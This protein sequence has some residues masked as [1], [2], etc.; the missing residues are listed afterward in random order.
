MECTDIGP[1]L[2]CQT[3]VTRTANTSGLEQLVSNLRTDQTPQLHRAAAEAMT[4]NGTSFFRDPILFDI[5]RK[6]ILPQLFKANHADRKLRIWSAATS[7]GQE[8][9]SVAML[10]A[11]Y[12]PELENWDIKIL[13]TDISSHVIDWA[14]HGRYRLL[15]VNR[16]LP[17]RMLLKYLVRDGDEWQVTDS[18]RAMCEFRR[19]DLCAEVPGHHGFDLVLLRNVLLYLSSLDRQRAFRAAHSQMKKHSYLMLGA[20]EQAEDSTNLFRAKFEGNFCYYRA[21]P[22]PEAA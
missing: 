10:I 5:L 1:T 21:L 15:D 16:G 7:T 13:G 3:P 12:F 17:A 19:L 14:Q 18:I 8:A 20:A 6:L 11:E 2:L 9:Y 22:G 4:I